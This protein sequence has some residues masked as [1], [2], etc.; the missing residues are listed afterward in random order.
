MVRKLLMLSSLLLVG[1]SSPTLRSV[2]DGGYRYNAGFTYEGIYFG[3]NF[4]KGK[5][6]G[7]RD[8]CLTA[9]GRYT[10]DHYLFNQPLYSKKHYKNSYRYGWY[11]GRHKCK[12]LVKK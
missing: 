4:T 10:K 3:R 5:K 9:K 11:L 1:C 7:I 8:G 6:E 2:E 12:D